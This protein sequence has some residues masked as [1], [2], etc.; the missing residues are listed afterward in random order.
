VLYATTEG[1]FITDAHKDDVFPN[2][3]FFP[4][5]DNLFGDMSLTDNNTND[6]SASAPAPTS[7]VFL[8]FTFTVQ[9]LGLAIDLDMLCSYRSLVNMVTLVSVLSAVF[10]SL[11]SW[12]KSSGKLLIFP[13]RASPPAPQTDPQMQPVVDFGLGAKKWA[14]SAAPKSCWRGLESKQLA[15]VPAPAPTWQDSIRGAGSACQL[16]PDASAPPGSE[17]QRRSAFLMTT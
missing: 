7:Y 10:C 11:F 2:E 9:F 17:M 12:I 3:D 13:T 14:A 4:D 6:G 8:I 15:G 5:I 1:F 16:S